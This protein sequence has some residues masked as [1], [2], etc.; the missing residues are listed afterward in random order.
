[1]DKISPNLVLTY[2]LRLALYLCLMNSWDILD[3]GEA[4]QHSVDFETNKFVLSLLASA[5][6]IQG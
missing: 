2:G 5:K 6:L 3:W 1:M 4:T